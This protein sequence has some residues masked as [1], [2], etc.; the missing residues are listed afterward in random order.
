MGRLVICFSN[1]KHWFVTPENT[2][3]AYIGVDGFV[4][5]PADA[6]D[7]T[8]SGATGATGP[9]G[10]PGATGAQGPQGPVGATGASGSAGTTFQSATGNT[11]A[12]G[13]FVWTFPT[14]FS[15]GVTPICW[16]MAQGPNPAG[17]VLVNIQLE[18]TPSNTTASF[19]VTKTTQAVV[20]LLGL[21]ILSVPASVGATPI[22]VFAKAP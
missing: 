14:P 10:P 9:A 1:W 17:G 8:G 12:A 4:H 18:G 3:P 22:T 5:D 13:L 7:F 6:V 19:R 2:Q 16:A 11:D 15:S 21:T 20:S